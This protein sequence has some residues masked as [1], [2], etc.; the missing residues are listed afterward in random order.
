MR[1][2]IREVSQRLTLAGYFACYVYMDKFI[3][4]QISTLF[5]TFGLEGA[6]Q[7]IYSSRAMLEAATYMDQRFILRFFSMSAN[8]LTSR[9]TTSGGPV[10]PIS[11][12][13]M[14]R[15]APMVVRP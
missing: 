15:S 10:T 5:G 8:S 12:G 1:V 9:G 2:F 4:F 14:R 3:K 6:R 13:F 7:G 11:S